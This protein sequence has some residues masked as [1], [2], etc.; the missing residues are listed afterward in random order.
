MGLR[1]RICTTGHRERCSLVAAQA[2]GSLLAVS[3]WFCAC[4][5]VS[6]CLCVFVFVVYLCVLVCLRACGSV[7]CVFV[8]IADCSDC[9]TT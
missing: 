2:C 5:R 4:A 7:F 1:A 9:S 3:V 6:F 8:P